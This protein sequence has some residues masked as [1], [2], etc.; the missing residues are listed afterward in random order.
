MR[1][2]VFDSFAA[3]ACFGDEQP[4]AGFVQLDCPWFAA[5]VFVPARMV[6]AGR[7]ARAGDWAQR[8]NDQLR[9]R[10]VSRA[11]F[12]SANACKQNMPACEAGEETDK[13]NAVIVI[14]FVVLLAVVAFALRLISAMR[15][16]DEQAR[17]EAGLKD[18]VGDGSL[19]RM[20][21]W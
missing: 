2:A 4:P 9:R 17:R 12:Q 1:P 18:S 8:A 3:V 19:P 14:G 5:R 16:S 15:M 10:A 6:P 11:A 21:E 20:R 13:M 7:R